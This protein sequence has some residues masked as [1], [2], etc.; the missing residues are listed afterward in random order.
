MVLF[1][2]YYVSETAYITEAEQTFFTQVQGAAYDAFNA[3]ERNMTAKEFANNAFLYIS[4]AEAKILFYRDVLAPSVIVAYRSDS[5]GKFQAA[6]LKGVGKVK[7][8]QDAFQKIFDGT[9]TEQDE[10]GKGGSKDQDGKGSAE[11]G[12]GSGNWGLPMRPCIPILDELIDS[13]LTHLGLDIAKIKPLVFGSGAALLA[14]KAFDSDSRV[15]QIGFGASA[16]ALAYLALAPVDPN[17]PCK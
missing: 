7:A 5:S 13:L 14:Y 11:S 15:G 12:N 10:K 16:A 4:R 6:Y 3:K 9:A 2:I 8:W 1:K 17:K